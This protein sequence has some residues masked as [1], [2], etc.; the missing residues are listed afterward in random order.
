MLACLDRALHAR[1]GEARWWVRRGVLLQGLGR[2]EDA[3]AS[4]ERAAAEQP[5]DA[6][7]HFQQ[8]HVLHFLGRDDEVIA[9]MDR[10]LALKP[11]APGALLNKAVA[12]LRQG[13]YGPGF[14]LFESRWQVTQTELQRPHPLDTLWLGGSSLQGKTL[15]LTFEQSLGD[16]LQFCRYASLAAVAGAQVVLQVQPGMVRLLQSLDPRCTVIGADQA[17]PAFDLHTPL[18]SLPRAFGTALDSIP[19]P[20]GYLRCPEDVLQHWSGRLG[21][22]TRARVGLAWSGRRHPM[23]QERSIPLPTLIAGLGLHEPLQAFEFISLHK[24]LDAAALQTLAQH[25]HIRHFGA[26]QQDFADAAALC[27]LVDVVITIDTSLAHLAGALGRPT[28]VMLPQ[29]SCDWRWMLT[30][31]DSPWYHSVRLFRQAEAGR[32]EGLLHQV[33]TFLETSDIPHKTR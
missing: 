3:L 7:A 11:D 4:H 30:R 5:G 28:W 23:Q 33:R 8:G 25:P 1:P 6:E 16:T 19:L 26:E 15:L 27:Q 17:P 32:W 12:L 24:D 31:S 13:R 2:L 9:C 29:P 14:E 18:M 10:A 20:Q 21:P 22:A